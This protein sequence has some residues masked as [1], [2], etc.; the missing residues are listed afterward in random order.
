M[1]LLAWREQS[2]FELVKKISD[3]FPE[4]DKDQVILPALEKLREDKLQS[5]ERFVESYVRYRMIRGMGPLKI[6]IELEQ[7]GINSAL[8]HSAIFSHDKDWVEK[9]LEVFLKKFPEGLAVTVEKKKKQFR[10]LEQRGFQSEQIK[11]IFGRAILD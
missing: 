7:K 4:L 10:F 3:K 6:R 1:N 8:V 2:F 11:Q 9:C 5:D